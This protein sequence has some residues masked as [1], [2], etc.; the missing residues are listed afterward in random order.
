MN[1]RKW[2]LPFAVRW[3]SVA[4]Q[5]YQDAMDFVAADKPQAALE[6]D[7][8]ITS[9]VARLGAFPRM[10]RAGRLRGTRELVVS[11]TPFIVVYRIQDEAGEVQVIRFLHGAQQW[12][13][14]R[15]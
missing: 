8:S 12:P 2:V 14:V 13:K 7:A 5:Q 11:G 15:Q 10:G 9:A 3:S 6:Q 4:W 1:S